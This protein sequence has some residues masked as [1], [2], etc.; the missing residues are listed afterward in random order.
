MIISL[1]FGTSWFKHS[2]IS[3]LW[4]EMVHTEVDL[5]DVPLLTSPRLE[6]R[7]V[8]AFDTIS[9]IV[10]RTTSRLFVGFPLCE[11]YLI[12]RPPPY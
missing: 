11:S 5:D 6:W 12:Y 8:Q 2:K 10:S 4:W 9:S 3:F 7:S 1:A